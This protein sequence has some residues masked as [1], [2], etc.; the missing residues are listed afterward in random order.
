MADVT[1]DAAALAAKLPLLQA[2]REQELKVAKIK[3]DEAKAHR[4]RAQECKDEIGLISK[5]L[6]TL[7]V[8]NAVVSAE[9]ASARA[10]AAA[11][12]HEKASAGEYEKAKALREE[13][14]AT[15]A[16]LKEAT[17]PKTE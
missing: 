17:K 11:Q 1:K 4:A 2:E 3:E 10:Q 14:E 8:R 13:A 5:T 12:A 15:L 6:S 7:E 16:K 9:A